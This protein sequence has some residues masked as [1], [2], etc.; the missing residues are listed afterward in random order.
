MIYQTDPAMP[1]AAQKY[2]CAFVSLAFYRERYLHR[3]W[4]A[5]ELSAAWTGAIAGGIIS[6]DLNGDGDMDD[7]GEATIQDW[8]KLAE[9]LNLPVQYLGKF[10]LSHPLNRALHFAITAWLNPRT[11]FTHFV[12]GDQKPVEFDPIAG[13]SVTVREGAPREL[14][15]QGNGGHRL[16]LRLV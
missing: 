10:P 1:K 16:F 13:G 8:N 11:K 4:K 6:G 2:G 14:D 12:V 3:P 7:P 5:D 15:A 9:Y